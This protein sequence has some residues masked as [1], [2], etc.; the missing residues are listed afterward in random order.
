MSRSPLLLLVA[1]AALVAAPS[2]VGKEG[3]RATLTTNIPR[4][5]HAG[6]RLSVSWRLGSVDERGRWQ[7]FGAG[8][9]FL[10]LVSASGADAETSFASPGPATTG[11][12]AATVIVPR[13]GIG[14][15]QIGLRGYVSG[16][17]GSRASDMLFPITND[18][19]PGPA[20]TSAPDPSHG[21]ESWPLALAVLL[22]AF[23]LTLAMIRRA[24]ARRAAHQP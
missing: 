9:V 3:V 21:F 10:R 24:S 19:L 1:A 4:D 6:A 15:V 12:Y 8:E 2:A 14:D 23:V 7:P 11:T 18:P 16:A 5:A 20:R 17:G 13:G 22:S